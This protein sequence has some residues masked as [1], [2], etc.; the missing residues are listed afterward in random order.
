M[1]QPFIGE[2]RL[3]AGNFAP[4]NWALCDGQL[5]AI[6]ENEALFALIGTTYGGDGVSNF[7]LPDLR[8]RV[9]VHQGTGTTGFPYIAGEVGGEESVVLDVRQIPAHAHVV[10]ARPVPGTSTSPAGDVLAGG[11]VVSRYSG[12]TPATS[13]QARSV[14]TFGSGQAHSNIQPYLALN[15]IIALVGVFPSE[16]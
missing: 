3:F 4:T 1:S 14:N 6:S 12:T 8:S 13:M 2:I 7:A 10:A 11:T 5:L 9:P 16:N 15:F